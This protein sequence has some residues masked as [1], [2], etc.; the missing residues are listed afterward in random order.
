MTSKELQRIFVSKEFKRDLQ[1]LSGYLAGIKQERP[2]VFALAKTL[3]KRGIVYQLEK[4]LRDMVV[5]DTYLEFKYSYDCDMEKVECEMAK[6][7][8]RPLKAMWVDVQRGRF[9]KGW[10]QLAPI[11]EDVCEKKPDIFVWIIHSRDLSDISDAVCERKRICWWKQQKKWNNKSHPYSDL[12]YLKIANQFL[13][14]LQEELK[15]HR[16]FTRL[17]QT[18]V[19]KS[20][21]PS[22]YH[23]RICDFTKRALKK[24]S[25]TKSR[26]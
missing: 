9:A 10:S 24:S 25:P 26:V 4:S 1:E 19:A 16:P 12:A 6:Y 14:K 23:F 8:D 7:S 17:T 11:Y 21:F 5:D 20:D 18:I 13:H 22:T 2:I 15:D 3:W